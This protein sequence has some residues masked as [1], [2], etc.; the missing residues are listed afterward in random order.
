MRK[1]EVSH[2]CAAAVAVVAI[3]GVVVASTLPKTDWVGENHVTNWIIAGAT[4]AGVVVSGFGL[5]WLRSTLITNQEMV[6]VSR[7]ALEDQIWLRRVEKRPKLTPIK[8]QIF[9]YEEAGKLLFI[10][11]VKNDGE[12][13][14]ENISVDIQVLD[15]TVN[16]SMEGRNALG[17]FISSFPGGARTN[18]IE[19]IRGNDTARLHAG[20]TARLDETYD[21]KCLFVKIGYQSQ[22]TPDKYDTFSSSFYCNFNLSELTFELCEDE[23]I[24]P[25]KVIG[26]T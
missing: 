26:L 24:E 22:Y 7:D 1:Y 10:I 17:R 25:V 15:G 12:N 21:P 18:S 16:V 23:R 19:K 20:A 9:K 5:Y 4:C 2:I 6:R 13:Q 11:E 14:A 3:V 8:M